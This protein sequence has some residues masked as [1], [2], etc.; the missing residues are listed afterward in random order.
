MPGSIGICTKCPVS[1][2]ADKCSLLA[3]SLT[4]K[5]LHDL[6]EP[7]LWSMVELQRD[8][9]R[10]LFRPAKDLLGRAPDRFLLS[11]LKR[12]QLGLL[13]RSFAF[14]YNELMPIGW[15]DLRID[16]PREDEVPTTIRWNDHR[17]I[18]NPRTFRPPWG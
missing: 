10:R 6:V 15:H 18:S 17:G 1:T 8:K 4:S 5:L 14:Q 7:L 3:L 9:N 13:V 11:L 16:E 2:A 12:P